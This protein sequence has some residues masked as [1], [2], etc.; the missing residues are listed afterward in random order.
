M[1]SLV[2]HEAHPENSERAQA[3]TVSLAELRTTFSGIQASTASGTKR[4][5]GSVTFSPDPVSFSTELVLN[6]TVLF[7][8]DGFTAS[9][10][11]ADLSISVTVGG[12][13][14]YNVITSTLG[15]STR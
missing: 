11:S 1:I 7:S 9:L 13:L 6:E 12:S 3:L 10:E 15:K 2:R 8:D 14:T 5:L 4:G